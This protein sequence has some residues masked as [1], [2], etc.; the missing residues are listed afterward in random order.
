MSWKSGSLNLLEPSGPH[1]ACY[2]TPSFYVPFE[3][4]VVVTVSITVLRDKL[5]LLW[6]RRNLQLPSFS[7]NVPEM[8]SDP[9]TVRIAGSRAKPLLLP[10]NIYLYMLKVDGFFDSFFIKMHLSC[11]ISY[12]TVIENSSVL[13]T[14]QNSCR[15]ADNS[16]ARPWRKQATATE[17]FE[18]HTSYL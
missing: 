10:L 16:L 11:C 12:S 8:Y 2:G 4:L 3:F 13:R 18:F 9:P 17:D 7:L 1:W 5:P 14:H 6:F 15:G